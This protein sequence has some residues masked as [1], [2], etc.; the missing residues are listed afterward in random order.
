MVAAVAAGIGGVL[1]TTAMLL[2]SAAVLDAIKSASISGIRS[3]AVAVEAKTPGGMTDSLTRRVEEG[4]KTPASR[5]LVINTSVGATEGKMTPAIVYGVDQRLGDFVGKVLRDQ[6]EDRPLTRP[7]Q[8]YLTRTWAADHGLQA[9]DSIRVSAPSGTRTLKVAALLDG[10]IANHGAVV[11]APKQTVASVFGRGTRTD[12]LLLSPGDRGTE[13]VSASA[14]EAVDGAAGVMRPAELFS[15]Y[16]KQFQTSQTILAM[17][18]VIAVLT[19]AV[20]LFLAWRL[21]LNDARPMLARM[22]LFGVRTRDLMLGSAVVMVPVLLG[23]YVVGAALGVLVGARMSSFTKQITELTQQAV[24]PGVPW[25]MPVLG[26]FAA[27]VV[28]FGA[29]WLSGLRRFMKITPVEAVSGR[30]Q[31]VPRPGGAVLPLA[32]GAAAVALGAV[33]VFLAPDGLRMVALL[34]L[35]GGA[36]LVSVVLPVALGGLLRRGSPRPVRLFSGRQLQIG[37]RRNAALGVTFAVAIMMALTMAGVAS[38]IKDSVSTSVERWTQGQ[39]Y[40]QAARAGQNLQNDVFAAPFEKDLRSVK[41][42]DAACTFS[43][44]NVGLGDRRVQMW[45][46]GATKDCQTL[47]KLR[48]SE[49]APDFLT[50]MGKNDIAVSSS[51]A[52]TRDISAGDTL[53]LPLPTGH[54][55]VTVRAVLDDTASDGGMIIAGARLYHEVT[56]SPGS[57]AYYVGVSPGAN[58]ATVQKNIEAAFGDRYPRAVVLTQQEIRDVFASI[59]ARLVSAFEAFAWVMFVLAVL[60]GAATLASGLV[61]RQ[62]SLALTRLTG[63]TSKAVNRQILFESLAIAV[64]AWVIAMPVGVL[65]INPMLDAQSLQSGLLPSVTV[66]TLLSG[67]SLPLVV[68]CVVLALLVANPRRANTSLRDLLAQE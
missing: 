46:W 44:S 4:A 26:A 31:T 1:L 50:S 11:I 23:S 55:T 8:V 17:F 57:Y 29:A 37:W 6:I 30:D 19:S 61:E 5:A 38:S 49:G 34:P 58:P 2:I 16:Q 52:R 36:A 9:G 10:E 13:A 65:S 33:T 18:A 22:R 42:V 7:D 24:T 3:D 39:L 62:R 45:S 60:V 43:Y 48:V 51:F 12:V 25:Q 15:G 32:V 53:Q 14:R 21:A 68:V 27:A 20:V 41:D 66:P 59:T 67:L 64:T 47:T 56:D 54:R 40:V 28:M 35:L 63:S